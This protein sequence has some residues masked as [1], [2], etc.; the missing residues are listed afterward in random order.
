MRGAT[1]DRETA[2]G[3]RKISI[4]APHAGS[5]Y[6]GSIDFADDGDFNPRSPCGERRGKPYTT[7]YKHNFNPRSPC[8]ERHLFQK[9]FGFLFRFQS[10]L[11]MRG[12]TVSYVGMQKALMISIHAPH[13]GSDCGK[14]FPLS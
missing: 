5:D 14:A 13:A 1:H 3:P 6:C 2:G 7:D 4:H 12:A 9:G 8:G 11:P 10:T